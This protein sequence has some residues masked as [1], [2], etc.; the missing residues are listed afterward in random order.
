MSNQATQ[1]AENMLNG[2]SV[3]G[4]F[5]T[6]EAVQENGEIA[7]FKF[8]NSNNWVEGG[9]NRSEISGFYGACQEHGDR[10]FTLEN[11]EPPVLLSKD[12]APNPV[13][14][15]LHALAGCITTTLVYHAAAKGIEIQEMETKFEGDLDL[16]GF[17]GL[18]GAKRRGYEEIR[19]SMRVKAD[20]TDEQIEELVDLAQRR[21]PVFDTVTNPVPVKINLI[22]D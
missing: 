7:K 13:E 19:I 6:I 1:T 4:I 2:V 11:D 5:S 18:P 14:Y 12:Q 17:L 16:R 10:N 3:D 9:L 15:V 8:R 22:K 20:A 21:S